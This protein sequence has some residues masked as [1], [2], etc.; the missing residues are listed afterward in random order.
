MGREKGSGVK[1]QWVGRGGRGM[2][3]ER[4]QGEGQGEEGKA[5]KAVGMAKEAM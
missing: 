5:L 1:G 2:G 3:R 4:G